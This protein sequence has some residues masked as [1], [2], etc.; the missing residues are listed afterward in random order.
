MTWIVAMPTPWGYSIGVSDV[1][2]T[3]ADGSERDCLQKIYP[4]ANSLALGFAGS[5][6]IGLKMVSIMQTS[7]R[8]DDAQA[9]WLPAEVLK[10][11]SRQAREIFAGASETEKKLKSHLIVLSADPTVQAGPNPFGPLT[12]VNILKSP[13][14]APVEPGRGRVSAIGGSGSFAEQY[15]KTLDEISENHDRRFQ[16]MRGEV[17]NPGGTGEMLGFEITRLIQETNP[18]G[19]S[20]HLHY[21]WVY[22]GKTI[23]RTN[24]HVK[25]WCLDRNELRIWDQHSRL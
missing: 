10:E 22:L 9:H 14:F 2:V 18:T 16:L 8:L 21:C 17:M 25:K 13:D 4:I 7:L 15:K 19:I 6:Y 1:R 23:I 24:D 5:V 3:L 12:C 11:I 20:S